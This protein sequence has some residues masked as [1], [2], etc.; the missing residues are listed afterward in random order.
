[1]NNPDVI[2]ATA[3]IVQAFEQLGVPYY[4]GGS[5][6]SSLYG[7]GRLTLDVDVVA[8]VR[9]EHARP[10]VAMLQSAY[11]VDEGMILEAIQTSSS[12]NAIHLDTMFKIDVFISKDA[13]F[14]REA[15]RRRRLDAIAEEEDAAQF[16]VASPEDVVL[17]KLVW[18]R[19]GGRV[20]E[21]QWKDVLGVLKIQRDALDKDYLRKWAAELELTKMLEQAFHDAGI[22]A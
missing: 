9:P 15:L 18:Y 7:I 21:R 16:Y 8:C 20:S 10:L 11:Y 3:P 4:V 14:D 13:P 22:D 17:S 12:F 2:V 5:V 6:A 19:S 1:V